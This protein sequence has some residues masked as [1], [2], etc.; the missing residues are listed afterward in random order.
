[1]VISLQLLSSTLQAELTLR[2]L[3][4]GGSWL[5]NSGM[6]SNGGW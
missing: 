4:G 1:M 2:S 5:I 6:G 3:G